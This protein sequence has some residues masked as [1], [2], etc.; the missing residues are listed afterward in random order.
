M[1]SERDRVDIFRE[2]LH[3]IELGE[4]TVDECMARYPEV[5]GLRDMLRATDL[6]RRLPHPT[7][8][9]QRKAVLA[10]QL[11]AQLKARKPIARSPVPHGLHRLLAVTAILIILVMS[12]T[13]LLGSAE[14][15]VPGDPLYGLKRASEN[16]RLSFTA[17]SARPGAL[18]NMAE[19]RLSEL[20]ALTNR[21]QSISSAFLT[22]V[23]DS[24]YAAAAAQ[25]DPD[26]R[27]R[28]YEQGTQVLQLMATQGDPSDQISS[29]TTALWAV[30]TPTPTVTP[31]S[32][33]TEPPIVT[34]A[35]A[36]LASTLN[37][38]RSLA[39]ACVGDKTIYNSLSAKINPKQLRAFINAVRAQAG[40]KIDLT[41]ANQLIALANQALALSTPKP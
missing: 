33:D 37:T 36:P 8:S 21:G 16:I 23:A 11:A 26:V 27:A 20:A 5:E 24:L 12:A 28:L 7:M 9:S 14:L 17:S 2:C 3:A 41:C 38:L 1:A 35:D 4:A 13:V 30:A 6:V 25:P 31:D 29:L 10:Q 40:K 32:T 22:D 19:R 39:A 18:S 15:A 34:T